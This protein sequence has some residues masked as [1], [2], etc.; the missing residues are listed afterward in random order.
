MIND[1]AK[2]LRLSSP[3]SKSSLINLGL[4][5][6]KMGKTL[7]PIR[8]CS[9]PVLFSGNNRVPVIVQALDDP[10]QRWKQRKMRFSHWKI[11]VCQIGKHVAV[12]RAQR[13]RIMPEQINV[14]V[15][16]TDLS[17]SGLIKKEKWILCAE[18]LFIMK[19]KKKIL[20]TKMC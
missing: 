14:N 4:F 15:N 12:K 6:W 1:N 5:R 9:V 2:K 10:K 19:G 17:K 3:Y 13:E 8:F 16:N 11:L 7:C 18:W 20:I